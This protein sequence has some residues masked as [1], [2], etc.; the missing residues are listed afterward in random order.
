MV[1]LTEA[2]KE[3]LNFEKG[4]ERS[5]RAVDAF[6][7]VPNMTL[8]FRQPRRGVIE[9]Q[10]A[11]SARLAIENELDEDEAFTA[12]FISSN[13]GSVP[14]EEEPELLIV[15]R[16]VGKTETGEPLYEVTDQRSKAGMPKGH[17]YKP[18]TKPPRFFEKTKRMV[19]DDSNQVFVENSY[20][21]DVRKPEIP[22]TSQ[23]PSQY[24]SKSP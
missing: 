13:G 7:L 22:S 11:M 12:Q 8:G 16:V 2:Q 3:M 6:S 18:Q 19:E 10:K 21:P 5:P 17:F 20:M 15:M 24:R 23:Q 9:R 4:Q 14:V 1:N